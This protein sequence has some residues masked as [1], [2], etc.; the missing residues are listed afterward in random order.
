MRIRPGE[1]V[2]DRGD[3][4]PVPVDSAG[5][6]FVSAGDAAAV[7]PDQG[8]KSLLAVRRVQIEHTALRQIL[9]V[10]ALRKPGVIVRNVFLLGG[11]EYA[12]RRQ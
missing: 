4:D 5:I 10:A 12:G 7:E 9:P 2:V 6:V 3:G 11:P 8:G 1:P